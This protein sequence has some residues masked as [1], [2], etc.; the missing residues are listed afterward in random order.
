MLDGQALTVTGR[1]VAENLAAV[2]VGDDEVIRPLNRP[3]GSGAAIA[4][5][6][7][8]LAPDTGVVRWG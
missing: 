2:A 6:R 5:P 8:T 7:G 1:T 3:F 4:L